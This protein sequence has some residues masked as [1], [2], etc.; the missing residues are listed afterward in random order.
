MRKGGTKVADV[1]IPEQPLADLQG[2][3]EED[4]QMSSIFWR[5]FIVP[6]MLYV[7]V[8]EL[9]GTHFVA[10]RLSDGLHFQLQLKVDVKDGREQEKSAKSFVH[11]IEPDAHDGIGKLINRYAQGKGAGLPQELPVNRR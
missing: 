3:G 11:P 7:V 5:R 6:L 8:M 4:R 1:S 2:P 9:L 10:E